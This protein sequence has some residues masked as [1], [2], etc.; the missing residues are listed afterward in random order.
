M[1]QVRPCQIDFLFS[2]THTHVKKLDE[3]NLFIQKLAC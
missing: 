2:I 1:I 3:L